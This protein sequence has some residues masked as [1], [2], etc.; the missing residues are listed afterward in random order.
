MTR[1]VSHTEATFTF[2]LRPDPRFSL[3]RFP[4]PEL[5]KA[6]SIKRRFQTAPI[7]RLE[8]WRSVKTSGVNGAKVIHFKLKRVGVNRAKEREAFRSDFSKAARIW[9]TRRPTGSSFSPSLLS[10]LSCTGIMSAPNYKNKLSNKVLKVESRSGTTA[11][12]S[13]INSR[14]NRHAGTD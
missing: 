7:Q 10:D 3:G 5:S 6:A 8:N 14:R 4:K 2:T 13:E 9:A 1:T 11:A 12:K